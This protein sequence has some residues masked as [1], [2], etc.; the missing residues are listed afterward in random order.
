MILPFLPFLMMMKSLNAKK[1]KLEAVKA[2]LCQDVEDLKRNR[3]EVV[4]KVLPYVDIELVYSDEL[5]RLVGKLA[6]ASV[7]M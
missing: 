6:S 7:F 5:G 3:V 2:S 4:S 1:A